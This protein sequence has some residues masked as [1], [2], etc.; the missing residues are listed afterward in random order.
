MLIGGITAIMKLIYCR[1]SVA[2]LTIV[3]ADL[4]SK[5][6]RNIM[7][8]GIKQ[9]VVLIAATWITALIAGIS[10]VLYIE[11]SEV[12]KVAFLSAI[13]AVL[14]ILLGIV[15]PLFISSSIK[16]T[17][18][19][20]LSNIAEKQVQA[21]VVHY[22]IMSKVYEDS[23]RAN[24]DHANLM[25]GLK[26]I[27]KHNNVAGA[28]AL[29]ATDE[30]SADVNSIITD[31]GSVVLDALLTEKQQQALAINASIGFQ[32]HIPGNLLN[33]TDLCVI[34]GNAMDNAI[35]ACA[36]CNPHD[37]KVI[38]I[39]SEYRHGF[40]FVKIENPVAGEVS[41]VNNA[42]Q[43]TKR[44]KILHGIGLNSMRTAIEK[45]SGKMRLTCE[46]G[47][48]CVRIELDFNEV[49]R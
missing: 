16:S 22:E 43:T 41:I 38:S 42:V 4:W 25:L 8:L 35:E 46:H 27:L 9:K 49:G 47:K 15:I 32:G 26:S 28:L 3:N 5:F 2:C 44:S 39:Q 7:T 12:P 17:Y 34:F 31:T 14:V 20:G 40:L 19:L 33:A 13:I 10:A 48:F 6:T 24:H 29:I 21:Q 37:I 1:L 30:V 18:Y 45:N 36:K 23:R 11:Y